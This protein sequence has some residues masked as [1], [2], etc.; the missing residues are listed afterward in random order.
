MT[1]HPSEREFEDAICEALSPG[2]VSA[3]NGGQVGEA[4]PATSFGTF[5]APGG[6][7]LRDSADDYRRNL[8]LIPRDV[9]DFVVATQPEEWAKYREQTGSDAKERFCK[10]LQ[11]ELD[12]RGA[13]NVLRGDIRDAGCRFKL[14]YFRPVS[15]L[16]DELK[17]LYQANVFSVVRQLHYSERNENSLDLVLFLN[18]IPI[19]TA[20]LKNPLSG[21]NVTHAVKQYRNDR[22]PKER[23][24]KPGRCLTHFAVDPDL[25]MFTTELKKGKTR[26]F[27]FNRGKNGGA[28]NE[29]VLPSQLA[30]TGG[31]ATHYLWR[32]VW[33]RDSVLN[34]I[35]HFI[36]EFDDEDDR[37]K[38]KKQR[39]FPRY[40]Q[41][42]AVRKLVLDAKE[43]GAGQ[44]YLIQH[45]AGSGKSNSIAW[46]SHQLADLHDNDDK[47]VFDSVVVITDRKVLD[48]QLQRVIL[49]F[50]QVSGMVENIDATSRQLKEALESGKKVVVTTLQKFPVI[51]DQM[52]ALPGKRF[53]VIVDEA[54]SSQAG[55]STKHL[56][57]VLSASSLED[58]EN[59]DKNFEEDGLERIVAE[60]VRK[61][62]RQPNV[63]HF[64]F[65]ATPKPK[66]LELFGRK[67]ASD[68]K[69]EPFDLYS[70]RQA[71]EEGFI[72]DVLQ[73]YTTYSTYW[74]LLKTVEDDPRYDKRKAAYLLK[75]FVDLHEHAIAEKVRVMVQHFRSQ[76]AGKIKGQA[77]AMIV[78]RSRLHAVRYFLELK[79]QLAA[80]KL[81]YKALV[82]FSDT[83]K[84][85]GSDYTEASLNGV[86]ES[87][88][89]ATFAEKGYRFLV[90]ANKFQTGFDE[91]LLHTMYVDKQ[92]RGVGAV[93]TLSRLN[94][95]H[96]DKQDTAVLDFANDAGVIQESFQDYFETTL[97]SEGTDPNLLYDRERQLQ[98]FKVFDM[99]RD[100]GGFAELFFKDAPQDHLHAHLQP[101]LDRYLER[102][103]EE[104]A[105][106]KQLADIFVRLYGFL[107][108]V[109][110]FGDNDLEKLFVFLRYLRR[111]LPV[112]R[113]ELPREVTDAIDLESIRV[114]ET[115]SG[116]ID[117]DRGDAEV[118]PQVERP[119]GAPRP[120]ME[121][122]LSE[123]IAELN[124]RHGSEL[125]PEDRITRAG[126]M[127]ALEKDPVL[128]KAVLVNDPDKAKLAFRTK[129]EDQFQE[130]IDANLQFYHRVNDDKGYGDAF[131]DKMFEEFLGR[132]QPAAVYA[133]KGES[134]TLEFKSSLRWNLEKQENDKWITHACIKTVAA[135]L[136]TD[137]GVL[138]IG[139]ND[140]GDAVGVAH[141]GLNEG[142]KFPRH[143][144]EV[145]R[146]ALG[147]LAATY[148]DPRMEE[149][150][151][152]TV[153]KVIC[154][155]SSVPVKLKWKKT[156]KDAEG[157]FFVRHGPSSVRLPASE[158]ET[159]VGVRWPQGGAA[160]G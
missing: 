46:L 21:Q 41:L 137:G 54:H 104:Q 39:I 78:T 148:V 45:S 153:C 86:S 7:Q 124:E 55:E 84:D 73:N 56:K 143:V 94:R 93:Q 31:Y 38:K 9:Y 156:E 80:E 135:F 27:P 136:N 150:G 129:A 70:M 15:G 76:V 121:E 10:R 37:G 47:K 145:V 120:D 43:K 117:L 96:P 60:E 50:E 28:G 74:K 90:V 6:Y 44:R 147:V 159:F 142:D 5:G 123:I 134:K 42:Q 128:D 151:D 140:E 16:N 125:T 53:A 3:K 114:Q 2:S 110:P 115:G 139:V 32:E 59:E 87:K 62:G 105:E 112:T 77:K 116:G 99:A 1:S 160:G 106:F 61:R 23:L 126:L 69:F 29:R 40:H 107:S 133:K 57:A 36:H 138:L 113:E 33:A 85:G 65:T 81:P 108:Q 58:A 66:T 154:K 18:G 13:L 144:I 24:L 132:H 22:D 82:A 75:T 118:D 119:A 64:A 111:L 30:A 122:T 89:A 103:V 91:P 157:D 4:R 19:F 131:Y 152:E 63:S 102:A 79:K 95:C 17:K 97:L 35:R 141:D 146:N 127:A 52:K 11:R 155:P 26:F 88:T 12:Q 49:Q 130:V 51:S 83:V 72:L 100:V 149:V 158:R 34:L 101:S 109:V 68:G 71:I 14:A 20:E 25:V 48:R 8:G 67:R 92:L 98:E